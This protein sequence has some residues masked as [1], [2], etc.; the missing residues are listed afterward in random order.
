[1]GRLFKLMPFRD[2]RRHSRKDCIITTSIQH[3]NSSSNNRLLNISLG[4]AFLKTSDNFSVGQEITMDIQYLGL[5]EPFDI[6]GKIAHE[7]PGLGIG[8]RFENVY[9]HHK[10]KISYLWR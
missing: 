6:N 7:I 5:R 10:D 2:K 3:N 8:I 1:M 4:G 9:Q